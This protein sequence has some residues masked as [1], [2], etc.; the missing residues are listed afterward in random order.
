MN[1]CFQKT[2]ETIK[3]K[4]KEYY[5]YCLTWFDPY[6]NYKRE[7]E[8]REKQGNTNSNHITIEIDYFDKDRKERHEIKEDRYNMI[9]L[10]QEDFV[11][12]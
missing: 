9:R 2:K 1:D 4:L 8:E 5:L 7:K 12:I 3:E 6:K 10:E 11:D